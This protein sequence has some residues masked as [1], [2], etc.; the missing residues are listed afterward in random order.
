MKRVKKN[1]G[2]LSFAH[3][4]KVAVAVG[5]FHLG[6]HVTKCFWSYSLN[7]IEGVG[8]IDGEIM[9]TL[10][11]SF[12]KFASMTRSMS[13]AHRVEILNDHM[14]DVNW[15]K[16]VGMRRY[17]HN[18]D[19]VNIT[20]NGFFSFHVGKQ[21][22]KDKA[23]HGN[24]QGWFRGP[25]QN[26]PA[27]YEINVERAGSPGAGDGRSSPFYISYFCRDRSVHVNLLPIELYLSLLSLPKHR[28]R[29]KSA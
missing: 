8:Q 6:A 4:N 18:W 27:G 24:H 15:K 1:P 22:E 19:Q 29:L 12:N 11:A 3:F 13:K 2:T 10:W 14:R 26:T 28:P 25:L 20:H 21:D 16:L 7:F 5:K 9:E 23:G 17:S